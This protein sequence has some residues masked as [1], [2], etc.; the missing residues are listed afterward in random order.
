MRV[1]S[2]WR[3]FWRKAFG[4]AVALDAAE[5]SISPKNRS[6][7][8]QLPDEQEEKKISPPPRPPQTRGAT[9]GARRAAREVRRQVGE[10]SGEDSAG[11]SLG[12]D[13]L[14]P[15]TPGV[16]RLAVLHDASRWDELATRD[17]PPRPAAGAPGSL[18]G[19]FARDWR[20]A[21]CRHSN[22]EQPCGLVRRPGAV[23]GS[24]IRGSSIWS[25]RMFVRVRLQAAEDFGA[26]VEA[27]EAAP[28]FR[29]LLAQGTIGSRRRQ[30]AP[31]PTCN[32]GKS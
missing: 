26:G 29:S 11:D 4:G 23:T 19:S 28:C 24:A 6:T 13:S 2:V 25:K 30:N 20:D 22:R 10:G 15:A 32:S 8:D 18:P 5:K 7:M 31:Q 12:E 1:S 17:T 14:P 3:M 21:G 27:S 16:I 9:E